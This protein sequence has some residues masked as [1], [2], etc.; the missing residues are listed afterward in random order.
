M[1]GVQPPDHAA[2]LQ[3]RQP[4]APPARVAGVQS[5]AEHCDLAGPEQR[6][7]LVPDELVYARRYVELV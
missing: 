6:F 1:P 4:A 3:H 5:G 2:M 7:R